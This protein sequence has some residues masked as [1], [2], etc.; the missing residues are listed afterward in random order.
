MERIRMKKLIEARSSMAFVSLL[1]GIATKASLLGADGIR[2]AERRLAQIGCDP[3]RHPAS[4]ADSGFA[5]TSV[6]R[7]GA[8]TSRK[9]RLG[10][11]IPDKSTLMKARHHIESRIAVAG[12][13][14]LVWT[15]SSRAAVINVPADHPTIQGAVNA[16]G[17]NDTIQIASGVYAGQVL[18]SNKSLTL[19]GSPGTVLRAVPGMSQPY[20]GFARVPLV[21]IARAEVVLSGLTLEG[22]RLAESQ[23][24]RF[25]GI[26]FLGSG[27][28]VENCRITGFRGSTL[29]SGLDPSG[30]HASN[31]VGW[32]P[33]VVHIEVLKSI[34]ADNVDAIEL[35][36]DALP[37]NA[38]PTL[39]RTTF[40]VSDN[41]ITGNGPD[42]TGVQAG[43]WI[44]GGAAGEVSRNTISDHAYVGTD[45]AAFMSYGITAYD[46]LDYGHR[47][48]AP[49]QP[50]RFEGNV[51]RNNQVHLLLL[52]GD[53]SSIVDNTLD[54]TAPGRRPTG[55]ALSG[56]NLLVARNRLSNQ[57][58][59]IVLF[60]NDPDY[61]TYL[62]IAHNAQ[63]TTNRFCNVA[64]NVWV[65]PLATAT[66]QGTLG[67]PPVEPALESTRAVLLSWPNYYEGYFLET[68]PSMDGP[69]T[70]SNA[71]LFMQDGRNSAAIPVNS[72]Q[73]YF[74]LH[75]P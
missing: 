11:R 47:P 50:I 33:G 74:R 37:P 4:R 9:C 35:A 19:S 34:F 30:I 42:A 29:G 56:E 65:E 45:P 66:E 58:L 69:W 36:G 8:I 39:L 22:E 17:S 70:Q 6:H 46:V 20:A 23:V 53:S 2:P 62:G 24:G 12:L 32:A 67:C 14:G 3:P 5:Q 71:T 21:S 61:G 43:I 15:T 10:S 73:Q 44:W 18:I 25:H 7:F 72:S 13:L 27:G 57:P 54:G 64:T 68:A 1:L 59:G 41:T 31:P 55:L 16:A 26:F 75:H 52:R 38:D 51:L 40:V 28:R 63:L 48:L 60:G 49:L